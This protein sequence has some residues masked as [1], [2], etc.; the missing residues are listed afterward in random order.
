MKKTIL[1]LFFP[2]LFSNLY[3]QSS[4]QSFAD[5]VF[6]YICSKEILHPEIVMR[7]AI[8]E[9]GNF[10]PNHLMKK[11]NLFGF[12]VGGKCLQFNSWQESVDY[13]KD[14][15][16]RKYTNPDENYYSFLVRIRYATSSQYIKKLKKV[17][18]DKTCPQTE[19]PIPI[20]DS[21][22]IQPNINPIGNELPQTKAQPI[23][24][25]VKKGD[26]LSGI[27][28]KY[29]TNVKTIMKI[30]NL[31]S[32]VIKPGQKLKVSE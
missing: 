4:S 23:I 24:Y 14:W 12:R 15:Q 6:E 1:F 25:I 22:L 19:K 5:N 26:T 2:F 8:I 3:S 31:K 16:T 13:Y 20:V 11:N 29:K 32:T 7:Q 18:F 9:T 27:A 17:N 21:S 28:S 30:N 10:Y